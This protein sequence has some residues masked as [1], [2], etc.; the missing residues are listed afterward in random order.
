M[1]CPAREP[2][3]EPRLDGVRVLLVDDAA[4]V[5]DV[6]TDVLQRMGAAVTA[7]GSAETALAAL[8]SERPDVLLSD[9]AMPGRMASG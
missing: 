5:L 2:A 7:V 3:G 4:P 8:Q 6:V 9:I 1:T